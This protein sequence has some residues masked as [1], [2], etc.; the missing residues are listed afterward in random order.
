[1]S[2]NPDFIGHLDYCLQSYEKLSH[3]EKGNYLFIESGE[4]KLHRIDQT[5]ILGGVTAAVGKTFSNLSSRMGVGSV[6]A[7]WRTIAGKIQELN[8]EMEKLVAI[9]DEKKE[10]LPEKK[11]VQMKTR[12]KEA[13][14]GLG[15]LA[16]FYNDAS[17]NR[18]TQKEDKKLA[19]KKFED[20]AQT[21]ANLRGKLE[22]LSKSEKK[23]TERKV[24][25][26]FESL[27]KIETPSSDSS[28]PEEPSFNLELYH[29]P[30]FPIE[31]DSRDLSAE[32]LDQLQLL[33]KDLK[34]ALE[35]PSKKK[36]LAI[37]LQLVQGEIKKRQEHLAEFQRS[38][39]ALNSQLPQVDYLSQFM[40]IL[41]KLDE[42][43]IE[44]ETVLA[45]LKTCIEARFPK[46]SIQY[47]PLHL[48]TGLVD[49]KANQR[50]V[51]NLLYF[52]LN[53]N[54]KDSLLRTT[55]DENVSTIQEC[56]D[57]LLT[58]DQ[59]HSQKV[60][61]TTLA[62]AYYRLIAYYGTVERGDLIAQNIEKSRNLSLLSTHA[63]GDLQKLDQLAQKQKVVWVQTDGTVI[64]R[65]NISVQRKTVQNEGGGDITYTALS[66]ALPAMVREN[67]RT[68]ID[69]LNNL[70]LLSKYGIEMEES[71]LVYPNIDFATGKYRGSQDDKRVEVKGGE[72]ITFKNKEG[73]I[74]LK[75]GTQV[76]KWNHYQKVNLEIDPSVTSQELHQFLAVFGLPTTLLSSR[77]EDIYNENVARLAFA[78]HPSYVKEFNSPS[79]TLRS[80]LG[81]EQGKLI[82][83]EETEKIEGR[84]RS[85]RP[86][87][88]GNGRIE[89]VDAEAIEEF[90]LA[91]GR[92]FGATLGHAGVTLNPIE[93]FQLGN[94][95]KLQKIEQVADTFAYLIKGGFMSTMMRFEAGLIGS[96]NSPEENI[97][98]GSATEVFTRPLTDN[99]FA[100]GHD[101]RRYA[102]EGNIFV[103]M[104]ARLS[105]RLP[106]GYPRDRAGLRNPY[107][108]SQKSIR[109][110]QKDALE[111]G[112]K[113]ELMKE[114][115]TLQELCRDQRVS[116]VTLPTAEVMFGDTIG[117]EYIYGGI[118]ATEEDK[119]AVIAVLKDKHNIQT[120][121]GKPLEEVIFVG[122]FHK[123]MIKDIHE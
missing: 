83:E 48:L 71:T 91:G 41:G 121:D 43:L 92:G 55:F 99:Q 32:S 101:W 114:R 75:L 103:L 90:W 70:N 63:L 9:L 78:S 60:I 73:T 122:P 106:Y 8:D 97:E 31:V 57:L 34:E 36:D 105:E 33:A 13:E 93:I 12:L 86:K 53:A 47:F 104:D 107:H 79:A 102:I 84:A 11:L 95:F 20:L 58:L 46:V 123:N 64:R 112:L 10:L 14:V 49:D 109:L 19:G 30:L 44:E 35:N 62:S 65:R 115:K 113:G 6:V 38:L 111:V 88:I 59:K 1:M 26:A 2:I 29:S 69:L 27:L 85:M 21:T 118:V 37:P 120:I 67:L 66:F 89:F 108:Q 54:L 74:A 119:K 16:S 94:I 3:L 18:I 61:Q 98:T 15:K 22:R 68:H 39:G 7:D 25:T 50:G 72:A 87:D 80:I 23:E 28:L 42:G 45:S 4:L 76:E 24:E 117:S 77:A 17:H 40:G 82:S 81:S 110:A 52:I 116:N 96:G 100:E 56:A 51:A 5:S